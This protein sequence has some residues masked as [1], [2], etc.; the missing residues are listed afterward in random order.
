MQGLRQTEL[1]VLMRY[2]R[3]AHFRRQR[4][5]LLSCEATRSNQSSLRG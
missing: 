1:I 3:L 4:K 2:M 5:S